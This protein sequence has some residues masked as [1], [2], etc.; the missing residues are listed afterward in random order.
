MQIQLFF[1]MAI[2]AKLIDHA[3]KSTERRGSVDEFHYSRYSDMAE[4]PPGL[5]W[6]KDS[7]ICLLSNGKLQEGQ[8]YESENLIV[9]AK[10]YDPKINHEYQW[11]Q[12]Q[13]VGGDDF[14]EFIPMDWVREAV[15][16]KTFGYFVIQ[17][18]GNKFGIGW[19]A[20]MG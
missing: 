8:T 4:V 16:D 19:V 20:E 15:G 17:V 12:D 5:L 7:G 14:V 2:V 18:E 13:A 1:D 9:Y 6:V 11:M 10:G 3:E